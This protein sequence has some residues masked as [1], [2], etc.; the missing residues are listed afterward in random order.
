L[1]GGWQK[2]A[3]DWRV[4]AWDA[5]AGKTRAITP[6][7]VD[8][9]LIISPDRNRL[10]VRRADRV[11]CVFPINGGVTKEIPSLTAHDLPVG[12]RADNRHI[13]VATHHDANNYFRISLFDVETGERTS[14]KE[15]HPS[16]PVDQAGDIHIT[17]D[18]SGYVYNYSFVRSQ[19]YLGSGIR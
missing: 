6:G 8:S 15:I 19:L 11:W 16:I 10:L 14:W 2:G 12:W 5:R 13:Y 9:E 18:G 17:P 4:F 7:I 3:K 1:V